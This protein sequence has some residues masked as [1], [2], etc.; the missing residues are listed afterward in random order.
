[1]FWVA[2][3]EAA[4]KP[5]VMALATGLIV[6]VMLV[7]PAAA[8]TAGITAE[9]MAAA[10]RESASAVEV[11]GNIDFVDADL[12]SALE[13]LAGGAGLNLVAGD[14]VRKNSSKKTTLHLKNA[15]YRETLQNILTANG[16]DFEIDGKAILV[17]PAAGGA[18]A[19]FTR[20]RKVLRLRNLEAARAAAL[21]REIFPKIKCVEGAASSEII[22]DGRLSEINQVCNFVSRIDLPVPQVLIESKVV[23]ISSS[24]LFNLGLRYTAASGALS[25][26]LSPGS[27]KLERGGDIT[28]TLSALQSQGDA[29]VLATPNLLTLD[30]TPA[31][32][33]I[34]SKIPYA[35]PV[36]TS[37]SSMYWRV[38]YL[39]AGVILNITP[40]VLDNGF[41]QVEIAPEVSA[42]SEW[43]VTAAGEFPVITTRNVKTKVRVRD[44]ET[45]VIGG[46]LE[47]STRQ[48]NTAVPI[49]SKLPILGWFF[50]AQN[51]QDEKSEIIFMITPRLLKDPLG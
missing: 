6:L 30:G 18:P 1:L 33:R 11:R 29:N 49:L 16:L 48:T 15:D 10:E 17:Y 31:E 35:V 47:S 26:V 46:L 42:I 4:L 32:I 27:D 5:A 38:D 39:D 2:V 22:I 12:M 40:R 24:G 51:N 7:A 8:A 50:Q 9:V 43:R 45:I 37:G 44:G 41:I 25:Y 23:E 14:E 36:Q 3:R 19:N 34:G 21:L 13:I 20:V 28:I